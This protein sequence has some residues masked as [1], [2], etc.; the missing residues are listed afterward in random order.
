MT[1]EVIHRID[2]PFAEGAIEVYGLRDMGA[3]EWRVVYAGKVLHDTGKQGAYGQQYGSPAVA[4]RDAINWDL[5][6]EA[7]Q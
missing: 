5:G 4:L 6:E 1:T 3:Y 2:R 7:S